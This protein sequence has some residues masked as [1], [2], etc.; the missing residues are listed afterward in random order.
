MADAV[1]VDEKTEY[2]WSELIGR[3]VK[4]SE[5]AVLGQI[6]RINNYGSTDIAV[7]GHDEKGELEIP[8]VPVY[9]AM[10][11]GRSDSVLHLVV[12][13]ETF[14]GLWSSEAKCK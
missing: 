13:A 5:A 2:L 4:D 3:K 8:L 9:F 7:I 12:P 14:S 11:F 6:L 10:D 1:K